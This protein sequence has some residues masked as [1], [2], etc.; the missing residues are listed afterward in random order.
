MSQCPKLEYHER[1]GWS[2]VWVVV[3]ERL[4]VH[5]NIPQ[6]L[7]CLREDWANR[8]ITISQVRGLHVRASKTQ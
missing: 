7:W 4:V 2:L 1:L 6:H 3:W 8:V 5:S